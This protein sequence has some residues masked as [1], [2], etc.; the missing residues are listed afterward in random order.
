MVTSEEKAPDTRRWD[1]EQGGPLP[2]DSG[3]L[4][5]HHCRLHQKPVSVNPSETTEC[6]QVERTFDKILGRFILLNL[7]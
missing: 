1:R 5:R 3:H 7:C 4:A 2:R 6:N